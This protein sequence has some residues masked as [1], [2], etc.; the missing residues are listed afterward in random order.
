M[1]RL[2]EVLNQ[3]QPAAL[4]VAGDVNATLAGALVAS[5]MDMCLIH[6]EA[7]LRSFDRSMPEEINRVLT[8]QVAEI[9][10]T[11]SRDADENLA[12][13]GIGQSRIHFVGNSMI[14]SL[15]KHIDEARARQ[16]SHRYGL[17]RREFGVLTLHRP[18]NVDNKKILSD[19]MATLGEVA[20]R[21]PLLF[22]AHPRTTLNLQDIKVTKD[23]VILE[24]LGYIDFLSLTSDA[25]LVLTDSGG[26]Q[27]ETTVLGIPCLT[28]RTSTE[29]PITIELGTN[30]LVGTDPGRIITAVEEV[31][32]APMPEPV[33]PEG[34]DG[35]AGSRAATVVAQV[36]T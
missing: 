4:V 11:P 9:C 24:P 25:R 22:P 27:E 30:R 15:D 16:V 36:V 17:E 34:W 3:E 29:R 14:D 12:R 5:K 35:H 21:I 13:E 8:D 1:I 6:L 2:E 18:A 28:M 33:R 31:L 26:I 7:G 19:L 10:L 32:A 20:T 23:I